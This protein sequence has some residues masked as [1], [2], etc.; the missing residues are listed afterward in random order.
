MQKA[1]T[2]A[3]NITYDLITLNYEDFIKTATIEQLIA[4]CKSVDISAQS[5]SKDSYMGWNCTPGNVYS[6]LLKEMITADRESSICK[7][8]RMAMKL[9]DGEGE[10]ET[11]KDIM[12]ANTASAHIPERL[13]GGYGLYRRIE[14]MVC[15]DTIDMIYDR[16]R[17]KPSKGAIK[18]VQALFLGFIRQLEPDEYV[19]IDD[20]YTVFNLEQSIKRLVDGLNFNMC[21]MDIYSILFMKDYLRY[22]NKIFVQRIIESDIEEIPPYERTKK[23]YFARKEA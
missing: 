13:I 1:I 20:Y 14:W 2:A 22:N 23:S 7:Q 16:V 8:M 4:I 3:D 21:L 6:F 18:A 19:S 10:R 15:C 17:G 11:I 12:A 5:R 9:G